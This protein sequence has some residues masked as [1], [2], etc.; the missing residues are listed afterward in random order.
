[1]RVIGW[2]VGGRRVAAVR[3]T[4][5]AAAVSSREAPGA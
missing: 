5:C 2:G 4:G 1:M 3:V